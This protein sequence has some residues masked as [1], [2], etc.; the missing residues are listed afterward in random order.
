MTVSATQAITAARE[1]E[2]LASSCSGPSAWCVDKKFD[3]LYEN[4]M[5]VHMV[6]G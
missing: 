6:H 1:N 2:S 5:V 3:R 4:D